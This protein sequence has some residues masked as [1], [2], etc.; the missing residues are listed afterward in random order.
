MEFK[1]TIGAELEF[2]ILDG[3]GNSVAD[4]DSGEFPKKQFDILSQ[5]ADLIDKFVSSFES[6]KIS[7]EDGPGQFEAHFEP[8]NDYKELAE[9]ILS[10]K[11]QAIDFGIENGCEISFS[12]KP[13]E[14]QPGNSLHIHLS[15]EL[16]D[17]YGLVANNG[18]MTPKNGPE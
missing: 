5:H 18:V 7:A 17:P 4:L 15:A 8:K 11:Q 9:D 2:F 12:A 6:C 3:E 1:Y 10:F 14:K 13:I 16:F